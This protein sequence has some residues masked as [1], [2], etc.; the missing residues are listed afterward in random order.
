MTGMVCDDRDAL[1]HSAFRDVRVV[2]SD[3]VPDAV[4]VITSR[5]SPVTPRKRPP[6][7]LRKT[8]LSGSSSFASELATTSAFTF[9][10][11]PVDDSA[12]DVRIGSAPAQMRP[13][14]GACRCA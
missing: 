6:L 8:I 10:I 11:W 7:S 5:R 3:E 2:V 4:R 12:C 14:A 1:G 9:R 13:R